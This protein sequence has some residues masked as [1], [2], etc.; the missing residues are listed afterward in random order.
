MSA[1]IIPNSSEVVGVK[2]DNEKPDMTDIPMEAMWQMGAAFTYGQKKYGKNNYRNGM[3]VS[4][5]LAA[6]IRHIFQHLAGETYDKESGISHMGHAL[7]SL[8]MA[9]YTLANHPALDD[10]F[11]KDRLKYDG[12]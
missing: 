4:R 7:A 11:D 9:C 3:K 2:H 1:I 10:R 8:A 6:A 12:N 5:Q